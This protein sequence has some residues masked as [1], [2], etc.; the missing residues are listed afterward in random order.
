MLDNPSGH[1]HRLQWGLDTCARLGLPELSMPGCGLLVETCELWAALSE[2]RAT[3]QSDSPGITAQ[4][5]GIPWRQQVPE[6]SL[7]HGH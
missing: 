1:T 7:L 5:Q 4:A 3:S 2:A 6:D